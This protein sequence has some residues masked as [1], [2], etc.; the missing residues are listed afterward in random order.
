MAEQSGEASGSANSL[1]LNEIVNTLAGALL[2]KRCQLSHLSLERIADLRR[3]VILQG[4]NGVVEVH[5]RLAQ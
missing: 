1:I 4:L 3:L 2:Q 5:R